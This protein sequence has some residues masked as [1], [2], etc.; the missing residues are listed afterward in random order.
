MTPAMKTPSRTNARPDAELL[1]QVARGELGGL[2]ELYDRY[3]R[4]VWRVLTRTMVHP[5]DVDDL[6]QATFLELPKIAASFDGR[7]SCRAW[8]CGIAVRLASRHRRGF[9]R[10]LRVLTAFGNE[11]RQRPAVDPQSSAIGRQE[12]RVL[13]RALG[14]LSAKKREVFVLVELEGL[15][16]DDAARALEIPAATVRTRLFHARAELLEGMKREAGW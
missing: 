11:A 1:T 3:Q 15:A 14:K 9:G 4:D 13:E 7:D 2:G 6:V 5:G 12:L 8:L 10:W 16:A